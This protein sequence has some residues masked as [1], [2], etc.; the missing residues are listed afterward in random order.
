MRGFAA[1]FTEDGQEQL[2]WPYKM[3]WRHLEQLGRCPARRAFE[4]GNV[5]LWYEAAQ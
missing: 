1:A 5:V 2:D 4:N 3:H